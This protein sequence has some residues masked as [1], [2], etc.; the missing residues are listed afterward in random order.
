M[1][2]SMALR[3]LFDSGRDQVVWNVLQSKAN[4]RPAGE[5]LVRVDLQHGS[6]AP[7][8]EVGSA[9]G[10]G[11]RQTADDKPWVIVVDDAASAG[12]GRSH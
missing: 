11:T 10:F 4:W 9:G 5:R 7:A 8:T 12:F 2:L 3:H 1:G 6:D